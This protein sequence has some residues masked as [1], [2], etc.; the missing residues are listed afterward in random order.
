MQPYAYLIL[1]GDKDVENRRQRTHHR[2]P[3]AI[4]ASRTIDY[5]ACREHGLDPDKLPTGK[6]LGT[7]EVFD[8][9]KNSK[10]KWAQRGKYHWLLRK[11]KRLRKYVSARGNSA[12]FL[13]NL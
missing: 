9:V 4:H 13:V 1:R 6:V 7:V 12:I 3:L 5:E 2:G 11:P 10:S 8:C